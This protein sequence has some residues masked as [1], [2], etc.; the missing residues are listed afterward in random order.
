MTK[1]NFAKLLISIIICQMA[2][3]IGSVFTTPQIGAWYVYL[4]KPLLSPPNW[5]FGPVWTLL[6]ILMGVSLWFIWTAETKKIKKKAIIFFATQLVLNI[7]W[8]FL[9][10]GIQS[11]LL[12]FLGIICL[13]LA[14]LF[15]ILEFYK[16][17]K[18]A[19][20]LLIPYIVWVSFA[21]YLNLF[22]WIINK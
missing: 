19:S 8:S 15:T 20:Y 6:F 3:V 1:N 22:I 9:F 2:G 14:I 16:I 18:I 5:V 10:F 13:W 7:S 4:K 11:P 12:A 17:S 21:S